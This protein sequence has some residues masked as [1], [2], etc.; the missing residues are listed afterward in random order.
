V[1]PLL[2]LDL[3][4]VIGVEGNSRFRPNS[5]ESRSDSVGSRFAVPSNLFD[6]CA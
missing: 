5:G 1:L 4:L 2:T 3:I 6:F